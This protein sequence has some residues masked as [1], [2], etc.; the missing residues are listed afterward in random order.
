MYP[1]TWSSTFS[2]CR[3]LGCCRRRHNTIASVLL[4]EQ[5]VSFTV[6]TKER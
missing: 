6:R 5:T 1:T 4:L 3:V 2:V